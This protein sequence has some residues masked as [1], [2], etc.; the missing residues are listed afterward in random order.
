MQPT[1]GEG[2]DAGKSG[3]REGGGG[4]KGKSCRHTDTE[5]HQDV[6]ILLALGPEGFENIKVQHTIHTNK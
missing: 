5:I 6:Q 4:D 3:G 2:E 1:P